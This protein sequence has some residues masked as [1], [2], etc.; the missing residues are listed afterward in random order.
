MKNIFQPNRK[1]LIVSIILF[2]FNVLL[3]LQ[4]IPVFESKTVEASIIN[5]I[6]FPSNFIFED[7]FK[8]TSNRIIDMISWILVFVYDYLIIGIILYFMKGGIK[9]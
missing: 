9:K 3:I 1:L 7:I 6:I 8:I 4:L 2:I 5:L